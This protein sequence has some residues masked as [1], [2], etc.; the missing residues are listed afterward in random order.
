MPLG[1]AP[2]AQSPPVHP[3]VVICRQAE[4]QLGAYTG[5]RLIWVLWWSTVIGA[6]LQELSAR[7]GMVSGADLARQP[8]CRE[9]WA[10]PCAVTVGAWALQGP[11]PVSVPSRALRAPHLLPLR[12]VR[13]ERTTPAG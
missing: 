10:G 13:C 12:R 4:M 9:D 2:N 7:I 8:Q 3:A 5:A 1:H 6:M 11:A